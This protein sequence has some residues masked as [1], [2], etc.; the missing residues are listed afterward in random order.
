MNSETKERVSERINERR[1]SEQCWA[2]EWASQQMREWCKQTSK[3][4]T[5]GWDCMKS[6]HRVLGHSLIHLLGPLTHS[7][8]QHCLLCSWA[9]SRSFI[10][11]LAHSLACFQAHVYKT[12]CV[13]FIS[14]LPNVRRPSG[15]QSISQ[16]VSV[17]W[18]GS[19]QSIADTWLSGRLGSG[20]FG[21]HCPFFCK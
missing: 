14:F 21:L 11:S 1:W 15:S 17:I 20:W 8:A 13:D 10:F 18:S 3:Q 7:L 6:M 5:V 4:R 16:S 12:E 19:Q 2:S 9:M